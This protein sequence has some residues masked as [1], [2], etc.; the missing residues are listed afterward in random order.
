MPNLA[1]KN[2]FHDKVRFSVTITGIVFALVLIIIQFGL[3]L[4]FLDTTANVVQRSGADLWVSAPGTPH[5]NG[6]SVIPERRRYQILAIPGV[7]RVD[8]YL[9]A[10]VNWKLPSGAQEAG[11][12]VGFALESG[13][14]GPWNVVA[15]SVDALRGDDTVIVDELFMKKLG[16]AGVGHH[17]EINGRRARVVGLTR[18]IRSFTTSP[19]IFTSFKNAQNYIVGTR[20]EDAHFFLVKA[21]AGAN[22]TAVQGGIARGVPDVEVS[23]NEQMRRRTQ[24]YWLFSTGAGVTTLLGAALGLMVGMVVVAQTIY[25]TTMDHIREFGTLKA[26]GAGNGYIYRVIIQQALISA[27]IGYVF[28]LAVGMFIAKGSEAGEAAILL[29]PEM[30]IG[31]FGLAVLMCIGAS[32]ISIRK[33]T[34]IDPA[35][36]FKGSRGDEQRN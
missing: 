10:F 25:A 27:A 20:E 30:A 35:L 15:G 12:V 33:A 6:G 34:T 22:L 11:Q 28:A 32:I 1:Y 36:V 24:Y 23:T 19:Y 3:F 2:L 14:G 8:K 4:G 18:G 31:T 29:P 16:V 26:M 9:L 17:A 21:K 5:V 13:L 7:G